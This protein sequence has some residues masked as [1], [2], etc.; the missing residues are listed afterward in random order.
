MRSHKLAVSGGGDRWT[1]RSGEVGAGVLFLR[2][3]PVGETEANYVPFV[4]N[5]AVEF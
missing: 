5:T 1:L 2:G 3:H 4:L